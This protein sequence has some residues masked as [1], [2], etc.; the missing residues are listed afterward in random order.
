MTTNGT[1][2]PSVKYK[3]GDSF[4]FDDYP[5]AFAHSLVNDHMTTGSI[6]VEPVYE[7]YPECW[8]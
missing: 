8:Y 3:T 6:G 5:T 7:Q 2:T 1:E 4:F